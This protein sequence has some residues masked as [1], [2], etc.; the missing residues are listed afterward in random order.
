MRRQNTQK[1]ETMGMVMKEI[2]EISVLD[3][4]NRIVRR[5]RLV[6]SN[7]GVETEIILEGNGKLRVT[8]AV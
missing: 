8:T 6:I 2:S 7:D 1:G 4:N 5:S 3:E